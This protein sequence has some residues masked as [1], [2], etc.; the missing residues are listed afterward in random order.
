MKP[1]AP[2]DPSTSKSQVVGSFS[3]QD[4]LSLRPPNY[5]PKLHCPLL[6]LSTLQCHK[7]Y[8]TSFLSWDYYRKQGSK[9]SRF[10]P[11]SLMCIARFL[12]TT[13]APL[14][15][16][17]FPKLCPRIKHINLCYYH[18]C[19]HVGKGLIKIFPVDIKDQIADALTLP[20]GK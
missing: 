15:W 13:L 1:F 8:V 9:I 20:L 18:F 4:A 10:F 12:K 6:K 19:E 2:V 5:N 11:P 7:L 16:Q 17:G 14:N 3:M